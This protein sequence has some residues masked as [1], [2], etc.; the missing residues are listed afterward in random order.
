[1]IFITIL[2][3]F[4][5]GWDCFI[6]IF[7]YHLTWIMRDMMI[8]LSP[9]SYL[10]LL[11]LRWWS[12]FYIWFQGERDFFFLVYIFFSYCNNGTNLFLLKCKF[13]VWILKCVQW[14]GMMFIHQF[15]IRWWIQT[16]TTIWSLLHLTKFLAVF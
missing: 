6:F 9:Q 4:L 15:C 3:L 10:H 16:C 11:M 5:R 14:G 13:E 12:T 8:V 2:S 7:M 1:M